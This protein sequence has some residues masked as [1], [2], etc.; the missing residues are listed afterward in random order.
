MDRR[1]ASPDA[2]VV[3]GCRPG[4][5]GPGRAA[6][7]R[8]AERAA[9]AF[10]DHACKVV[11]ASGGRRWLGTPEA[12]LLADALVD[13]GVP[14]GSIVRE[15]CSLSTIENAWYSAELLGAGGYVRPAIVT[16][17]WHMPRALSYFTSF[18]VDAMGLCAV[19][20]ERPVATR[21]S[22]F[23]RERT[24]RLMDRRTAA[25]WNGQ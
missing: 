16:C 25:R 7:S 17:D 20:P 10:H 2:I 24:K 23:M 3:L 18:G 5:S 13:L 22:D 11:I 1:L 6:L 9:R 19:T 12:D 14:R 8:R 15:L 4:G 21:L